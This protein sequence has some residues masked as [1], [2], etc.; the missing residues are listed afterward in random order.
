MNIEEFRDYCLSFKGAEESLPFNDHNVLTF[1]V[2]GKVFAYVRMEPADGVLRVALKCDAERSIVLRENFRDVTETE[3]K[4]PL[5][6]AIALEG[7][8]P[9]ALIE[10]LV[11]HSVDKVV[12]KLPRYK[13]EEYL[14]MQNR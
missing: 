10:E 5:W 9:D 6:N 8:V 13:R 1:K 14:N 12:E 11:R 2:M 4:T 7:D 3:F